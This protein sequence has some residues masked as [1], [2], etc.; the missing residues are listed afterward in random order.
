[1]KEWMNKGQKED[2]EE[3]RKEGRTGEEGYMNLMTLPIGIWKDIPCRFKAKYA[4]YVTGSPHN[5]ETGLL[6]N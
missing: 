3:G 2:M 5:I 4:T 6:N 1:M